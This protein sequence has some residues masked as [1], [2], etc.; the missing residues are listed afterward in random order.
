VYTKY[1]DNVEDGY[2]CCAWIL[3]QP[4][5]DGQIGTKGLS[6][7]AHTQAALASAGAPGVASMFV[8][9]GG[10]SNSYQG[11]I[12]QGGAFELKQATWAYRNAM[13]SPEVLADPELQRRMEQTSTSTSG[14]GRCRGRPAARRS[15]SHPTTRR[16]SSSSG[17]TGSSTTTG[18][19]PAIYAEGFWDQWPD[20]PMV[21][22]SSWFDP[23][24][25]TATE[26]YMGLKR[27][28]RG[29]RSRLI[30]G[31]WTHGDRSLSYAGDVD[32]GPAATLDGQVASDFW[33]LRLR[34]FEHW[35]R[36][37]DNG[38]DAEP[39]VRYFVMGGGSGLRN[40]DGRMD[41]G[42]RWRTAEDWPIPGT[43][44]QP[45]YLGVGGTLSVRAARR[46]ERVPTV[47][48]RPPE[49]RAEHWWD[50]HF[51]GADHGGRG[52]R[53]ARV[54]TSSAPRLRTA[55]WPSAPTCWSSR[56]PPSSEDVEV[57]G[58]ARRAALHLVRRPDTD[59]TAKLVDVY[60]PTRT[61]PRDTR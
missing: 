23:Y 38:V 20:A 55:R 15:A 22:M 50:H 2:D 36:G 28:G 3:E 57:T 59:F 19:I 39:A 52:V 14:S 4:W 12:R 31:P 30:M 56:R 46:R 34:W 47:R 48:V 29:G 6:Y 32:F 10:F 54:P 25:R 53:P 41:H 35:L 1:L 11:G 33:E 51:G 24:P 45:Y 21:H 43:V 58:P 49:S 18:S 44:E 17:R 27:S 8:D 7:A 13:V 5:C 26:N 16:I 37:V 60:P 61:I 40:A 42:G 9:S